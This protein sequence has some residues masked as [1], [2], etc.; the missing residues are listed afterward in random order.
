[1]YVGRGGVLPT[2]PQ[3]SSP[4]VSLFMQFVAESDTSDVG[5]DLEGQDHEAHDI[6]WELRE[7]EGDGPVEG[8][9]LS[10][11]ICRWCPS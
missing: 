10:N 4:C 11:R 6:Y 9:L 7:A 5:T 1:M 8:P 3:E 2:S